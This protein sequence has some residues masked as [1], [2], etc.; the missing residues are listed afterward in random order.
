[1]LRLAGLV[2]LIACLA[3]APA[4]AQSLV[5]Q[6]NLNGGEAAML[7]FDE[8]GAPLLVQQGPAG[9]L[10]P[11][12]DAAARDLAGGAYDY[13]VGDRYAPMPADKYPEAPSLEPSVVRISFMQ[14]PTGDDTLLIVENGHDRALH[15]RVRIAVAGAEPQPSDVCLVK[16]MGRTFEHWPYRIDRIEIYELST[17]GWRDGDPIPCD[18]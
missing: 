10:A 17:Q 14:A 9:D 11:F 18:Y 6:I 1:M 8:G 16:P 13:A 5:T 7:R 4:A 3:A 2:A 15:Y 12:A